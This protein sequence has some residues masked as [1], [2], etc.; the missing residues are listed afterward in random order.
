ME[1]CITIQKQTRLIHVSIPEKQ[2]FLAY[3]VPPRTST[4]SIGVVLGLSV[5]FYLHLVFEAHFAPP[6]P[7]AGKDYETGRLTVG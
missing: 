4:S 5:F 1:S 3:R 7:K 6:P 2:S